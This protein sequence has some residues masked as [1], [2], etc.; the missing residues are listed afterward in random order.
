MIRN[1][2][3]ADFLPRLGLAIGAYFLWSSIHLTLIDATSFNP[4]LLVAFPA[5]LTSLLFGIRGAAIGSIFGI[6]GIGVLSQFAG[7]DSF[8]NTMRNLNPINTAL[9]IMLAAMIGYGRGIRSGAVRSFDTDLVASLAS[10]EHEF[11]LRREELRIVAS[12]LNASAHKSTVIDEVARCIVAHISRAI[13]PDYLAVAVADPQDRNVVVQRTVGLR[14]V[15]FCEG[16]R[17]SVIEATTD[18][19]TQYKV[20]LLGKSDLALL[21]DHSHITAAVREAGIRSVLATNFRNEGNELI[22]QIW[23]G[24]TAQNAFSK[25]DVEFMSLIFDHMQSAISNAKNAESLKLLQRHLVG[26]NERLAQM[27]DGIERT[28]GELRLSLDQLEESST[29]KAQ[30]VSSIAH[31]VKSPLAVMIGYADLLRFDVEN[32]NPEQRAYAESIE[33]SARQLMTVIEDLGDVESI[34]SGRFTTTKVLHDLVEI[35]DSVIA[36]IEVSDE[37]YKH[38]LLKLDSVSECIVNGDPVRLSQVLANL[39]GNALKYSAEDQRVTISAA[40]VDNVATVSIADR[41]LGIS[42]DDLSRLFTPYF[43]STNPSAI[44]KPGTG[45]GLFLSKSIIEEH[46]GSLHVSTKKGVGSI[47]TVELPADVSVSLPVAA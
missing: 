13:R 47:F 12:E 14:V 44:E 29:A 26:Q 16:D 10:R 3:R 45:L 43:R 39:V 46:G 19:T 42:E 4:N 24:S 20:Q 25:L 34:E 17:R 38:R 23:I 36:G 6:L 31:E 41:G 32:L 9:L 22:A 15:G 1:L 33:K 11:E 18:T 21:S 28:E 7:V 8:M 37:Q 40:L 27:Q 30:F 2:V 5:F 35:L